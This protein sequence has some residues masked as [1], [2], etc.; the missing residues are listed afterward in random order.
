MILVVRRRARRS[1]A[2]GKVSLHL[3]R[4]RRAQSILGRTL[5]LI[6]EP[7]LIDNARTYSLGIAY[8]KRRL[9]CTGVVA[10][11]RQNQAA[12]T[13]IVLVVEDVLEASDQCVLFS[14]RKVYAGSNI[15]P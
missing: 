11:A 10:R 12:D 4:R 15:G 13:D 1:A 3:D 9:R 7:R 2:A 5:A 8:L 14:K 6:L